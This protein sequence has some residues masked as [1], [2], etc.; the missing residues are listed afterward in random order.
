MQTEDFNTVALPVAGPSYE[1]RSLPISAQRTLNF[2]PQVDRDGLTE[3]SLYPFP[4]LKSWSTGNGPDRGLIVYNNALYQVAGS[5]L[6]SVNSSG[7]QTSVGAI[8]GTGQV[9]FVD[10]GTTLFITTG[11]SYYSYDGTTLSTVTVTPTAM[12]QITFLNR[13]GIVDGSDGKFY[14]SDVADLTTYGSANS[15][16]PESDPDA[17]VAPYAYNQ[18]LYLFNESTI[19]PWENVGVGSPPFE[20]IDGGIIEDVG[21]LSPDGITHTRNFMYFVGHDGVAYRLTGSALEPISTHP[22]SKAMR[23]YTLNTYKAFVVPIDGQRIVVFAFEEATWAYNESIGG[24]NAW[25]ELDDGGL[26]W[27]GSSY[28]RIYGKDLIADRDSGNIY[29][30]DFDTYTNNGSAITRERV[31]RVISGETFGSPR[32][33][34]EMSRLRLGLETGVGLITGQG[35]V[36]RV[37]VQFAVDGGRTWGKEF[38]V[39]AGR[40]GEFDTS[41]SVEHMMQFRELAI[42]VR[43]TDPVKWVLTSASIDVREAGH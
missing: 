26:E 7:T 6:Y 9:G 28:A 34:L 16:F 10:D 15:A 18:I 36:P 30:L 13:Q 38:W 42:R 11:D 31:L 37:M 29:E 21:C 33:K 8:A 4:G 40:M 25:F 2:Y 3:F 39:S 35:S 5:N 19:E 27:P 12:D 32:L 24:H 1:S 23:G 43:M 20:R 22:I 41:V 17:L 14:V